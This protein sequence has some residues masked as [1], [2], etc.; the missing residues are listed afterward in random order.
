MFKRG[1]VVKTSGRGRTAR[2]GEMEGT[3]VRVDGRAH[4]VQWHG[5]AVEEE[6]DADDLVSVGRFNQAMIDRLDRQLRLGTELLEGKPDR[7]D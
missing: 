2:W 1:E 4:F 3:V 5:I 7:S 6:M